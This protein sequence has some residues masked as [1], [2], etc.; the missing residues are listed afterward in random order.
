MI[1][2]LTLYVLFSAGWKAGVGVTVGLVAVVALVIAGYFLWRRQRERYNN[3]RVVFFYQP[4][5]DNLFFYRTFSTPK[6]VQLNYRVF[7]NT[8]IA[9]TVQFLLFLTLL[10]F[11]LFSSGTSMRGLELGWKIPLTTEQTCL[12]MS[13]IFSLTYK[14][15]PCSM[16]K[17]IKKQF[18]KVKVMHNKNNNFCML[19]FQMNPMEDPFQ[20]VVSVKKLVNF[21]FNHCQCHFKV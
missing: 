15:L 8:V 14:N 2:V 18:H 9:I 3:H 12:Q 11:V 17:K 5:G 1:N 16:K 6:S 21:F 7:L 19:Q 13:V 10:S 4:K 20:G